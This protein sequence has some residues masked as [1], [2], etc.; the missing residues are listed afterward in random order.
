[1]CMWVKVC[2]A[3]KEL[4]VCSPGETHN[5]CS[6]DTL[7][8]DLIIEIDLGREKKQVHQS[9]DGYTVFLVTP[10]PGGALC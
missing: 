1:M 7:K 4:W 10:L 2:P 5:L 3:Y 8:I 6:V 9:E